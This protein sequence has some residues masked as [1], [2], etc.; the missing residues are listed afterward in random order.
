MA[1]IV[2]VALLAGCSDDPPESG[3]GDDSGGAKLQIVTTTGM[4]T[5]MVEHIVGEHAEVT[6]LLLVGTDPHAYSPTTSDIRDIAQADIVV[7]SGLFLEAQMEQAIEERGGPSIAVTGGLDEAQLIHPEGT[8]EHPDP[9]VWNDL[10]LWAKCVE[11]TAAELSK[12]DP[13]HSDDY[14]NRAMAYVEDLNKLDAYVKEVIASIPEDRRYLVTAHDAFSYFERAYGIPVRSVQGITTTSEPATSDINE[15]VQFLV[16]NQIPAVFVETSV[17][18]RGLDAVR[19]GASA[20]GWE[21][22]ANV[23]LYSD[24]MGE[25]GTYEGTFIGMIDHNATRITQELG[26]EAPQGGYQGK[27][28]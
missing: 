3:G 10:Q 20:Q 12:A 25:P 2:A 17:S 28:E 23:A 24:S 4:V 13:E 18:S 1:A 7:Y 27:L 6:G 19:E 8:E 9:H 22:S 26:G 5:D 21:V 16:E 14:V 15:L 11:H